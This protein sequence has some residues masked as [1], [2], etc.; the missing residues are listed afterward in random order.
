M[1][2]AT[3]SH[4]ESGHTDVCNSNR[5]EPNHIAQDHNHDSLAGTPQALRFMDL[6]PELHDRIYAF[7]VCTYMKKTQFGEIL[8]EPDLLAGL[9]NSPTARA[10]SKVCSVIRC[11]SIKAYYSKNTFVVRGVPDPWDNIEPR[12]YCDY[13]YE[14][15]L[16]LWART[17]GVLGAQHI[18][19]L[20]IRPLGGLV[21]ISMTGEADPVSVVQEA[22]SQTC[23][24]TSEINAAASKAFDPTFE[25][26]TAAWKLHSFFYEIGI[27]LRAVR[28]QLRDE[29][30][31]RRRLA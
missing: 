15:P 19:S 21:H 23:L 8:K 3:A 29:T 7:A 9:S 20:R 18:R 25:G 28:E 10:L 17:W 5:P 13:G 27:A 30:R 1:A 2:K 22:F 4:T 24:S 26:K 12:P 6:P 14:H 31:A 16:G 11:K